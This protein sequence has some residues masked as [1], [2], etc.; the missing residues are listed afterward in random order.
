[1]VMLGALGRAQSAD[2]YDAT[3]AKAR[4]ALAKGEYEMAL[5]LVEPLSRK[6]PDD[7]ELGLTLARAYRLN[8]KLEQAERATQWLLDLRPEMMGGI[9]EAA[10]LREAFG[11]LNGAVELLNTVYRATAGTRYGE[12][13]KVLADL[14]RIFERQ[15]KKDDAGQ[16]RREIERLKE[17]EKKNESNVVVRRPE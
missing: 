16:L 4:E 13:A 17:L 5:K 7:Y 14:A 2:E 6:A 12:R 8:G 9:W 3:K 10:L 1:M 11:D 15:E